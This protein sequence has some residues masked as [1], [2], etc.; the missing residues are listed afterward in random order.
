MLRIKF[1]ND[2]RVYEYPDL[3]KIPYFANLS[4][5]ERN[6]I[7]RFPEADKPMFDAVLSS[8]YKS[9]IIPGEQQEIYRRNAAKLMLTSAFSD[10]LGIQDDNLIQELAIQLLEGKKDLGH[11]PEE[12]DER[13]KDYDKYT[14]EFKNN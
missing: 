4:V 14:A 10:F 8:D 12:A 2:E 5:E 11:S 6:E 3:D 9:L 1:K 7:I 13:V